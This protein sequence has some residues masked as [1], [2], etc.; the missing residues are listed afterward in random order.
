MFWGVDGTTPRYQETE[1]F[2]HLCMWSQPQTPSIHVICTLTDYIH[3]F[4]SVFGFL[5]WFWN[6]KTSNNILFLFM[7]YRGQPFKKVPNMSWMSPQD[8]WECTQDPSN[9]KLFDKC[10]ASEPLGSS[11]DVLWLSH[12]QKMCFHYS[13]NSV[14]LSSFCQWEHCWIQFSQLIQTL[15]KWIKINALEYLK[16]SFLLSV[17][18]NWSP[19]SPLPQ[20]IYFWFWSLARIHKYNTVMADNSISK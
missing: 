1:W 2:E 11:R 6:G 14:S 16:S 8:W 7:F 10:H 17:L 5:D 15:T 19:L 12:D 18:V 4:L 13:N 9:L 3:W 20:F